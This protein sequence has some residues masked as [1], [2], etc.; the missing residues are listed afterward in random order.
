MDTSAFGAWGFDQRGWSRNTAGQ[1]RQAIRRAHKW[2][3]AAGLDLDDATEDQMR[4]WHS[5]LTPTAAARN[6]ARKAVRA[7]FAWRMFTGREDD[8]TVSLP[9]LRES[10]PVT[11]SLSPENIKRFVSAAAC[12]GD[13]DRALVSVLL[14]AA[15]RASEAASLPWTAVDGEWLRSVGKGA[16]LHEV[17]LHPR[18]IRALSA[19]RAQC[20]SSQWVFPSDEEPWRHIHYTTVLRVVRSIG[21]DAGVEVT[22]HV[23]RHQAATTMLEAGADLLDVRAF[24][25]HAS[26]ATT[27]RYVKIR[28]QR[29]R[30]AV[31][32][33]NYD[34]A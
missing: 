4:E 18:T 14:Y 22:P 29:L 30:E 16:K 28:S 34:A 15:L 23:L 10:D 8:P 24:L 3:Q 32:R 26:V 25:A 19:W 6:Q 13:R 21:D 2:F 27:Q 11:R 31:A 5:S 9:R 12:R 20:P 33:L 17:P 1:Y 7:Y